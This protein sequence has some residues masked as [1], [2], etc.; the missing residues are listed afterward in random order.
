MMRKKVRDE[1]EKFETMELYEN[2]EDEHLTSSNFHTSVTDFREKIGITTLCQLI[3]TVFSKETYHNA[4]ERMRSNLAWAIL[5][6]V[7]VVAVTLAALVDSGSEKFIQLRVDFASR[8]ESQIMTFII[9][10]V[11]ANIFC[12][13]SVASCHLISRHAIGSG[14][15]E[16][17][18]ILSGNMM[19]DYLSISTLIAKLMSLTLAIAGGLFI[20]REGPFVHVSSCVAHQLCSISFIQPS[21]RT[22]NLR[23]QILAAACA[24]GVASTF[25]APVGGVLFSIEVTSTFYSV[26]HLWKGFF[27]AV[28]GALFWTLTQQAETI[29]FLLST[30]HE[31]QPEIPRSYLLSFA[32]LGAICGLLGA[33][34]VR[35]VLLTIQTKAKLAQAVPENFTG[36]SK[37]S[38][39][40]G[41]FIVGRYPATIAVATITALVA[42]PLSNHS[43]SHLDTLELNCQ[44]TNSTS[45]ACSKY[46]LENNQNVILENNDKQFNSTFKETIE[47]LKENGLP[48]KN[49]T[50]TAIDILRMLPR[51]MTAILFAKEPELDFSTLIFFFFGQFI[52]SALSI[53]LPISTGAFSALFV[54]GGA[55][56]QIFGKIFLYLFPPNAPL[57][58]NTYGVIGAAALAGSATGTISTAVILFEL[59][60]ELY[61]VIPVLLAVLIGIAVAGT[62]HKNLYDTMLQVKKLPYLSLLPAGTALDKYRAKDVMRTEVSFLTAQCT[63]LDIDRILKLS[64]SHTFAVVSDAQTKM[65]LGSVDRNILINALNNFEKEQFFESSNPTITKNHPNSP[66][67]YEWLKKT[68]AT[69]SNSQKRGQTNDFKTLNTNHP[70]GPPHI[71]T[72]DELQNFSI[73]LGLTTENTSNRYEQLWDHDELHRQCVLST[74]VYFLS[75]P[76]EDVSKKNYILMDP[77]PFQVAHLTPLTKIHILFSILGLSR[78]FVTSQGCLCGVVKKSDLISSAYFC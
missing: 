20:G 36:F 62:L 57:A 53:T 4:I 77:A 69:N 28:C 6:I 44:N 56:G 1:E 22:P 42:H 23:K 58:S 30:Q 47:T 52:L 32:L 74:V 37:W 35:F 50:Y 43:P 51:E 7:G 25:G 29:S 46:Y 10:V 24:A 16:M 34:F 15:P 73:E 66:S 64:D 60:G 65:L 70:I 5:V 49:R 3:S 54:M 12:C 48:D 14:I 19:T 39:K 78:A 17:K 13:A 55:F 68:T 31:K 67:C 72:L 59:T 63:F 2:I 71:R 45:D 26:S 27:C 9:W 41:K 40:F 8:Q 21:L 33:G 61:H 11:S 38:R 76:S 75:D 18:S